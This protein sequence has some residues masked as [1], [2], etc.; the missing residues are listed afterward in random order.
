MTL[1]L[2]R[3]NDS[4]EQI[5]EM[6]RALAEFH[7]L[8]AKLP[9]ESEELV[10]PPVDENLN[11]PTDENLNEP[12]DAEI[13][14][15]EMSRGIFACEHLK[16]LE[17][18]RPERLKELTKSGKLTDHLIYTEESMEAYIKQATD[19]L[20]SKDAEYL[21]AAAEKDTVRM[22]ELLHTTVMIARSDAEKM[23]VYN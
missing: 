8:T 18:Y 9:E 3:E 16:H 13:Y 15:E 23:F 1:E 11:E 20:K 6:D 10:F 5:A 22:A 7:R 14:R 21:Q 17:N 12:T 4:P 19:W 2:I